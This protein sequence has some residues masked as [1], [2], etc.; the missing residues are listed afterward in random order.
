[1]SSGCAGHGAHTGWR[2]GTSVVASSIEMLMSGRTVVGRK[3]DTF[4]RVAASSGTSWRERVARIV[5]GV[6]VVPFFGGLSL[7]IPVAR[8]RIGDLR[9][10][11]DP[12][13]V[14]L[15]A[16]TL[17]FGL[18]A[19]YGLDQLLTGVWPSRGRWFTRAEEVLGESLGRVR[20]R[21]SLTIGH[22]SGAP[23]RVHWS[24]LVGL[25]LVGGLRPGAWVGFLVVILAH[26]LGHAVLV[27]RFGQRVVALSLHALGGECHW[28]GSPTPRQRTLIAWG[29]VAGQAVLLGLAWGVLQLVPQIFGGWFGNPLGRTLVHSNVVIAAFNLLPIPPLDGVEAWRFLFQRARSSLLRPTQDPVNKVVKSALE[30]ASRNQE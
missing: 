17:F 1:M 7:L 13:E 4:R 6:V 18:I 30:R 3:S 25:I 14:I 27:R 20:G 21:G 10:K 2:E 11:D 24:V 5:F 12:P 16:I 26:E 9:S 29:G 8:A 22:V 23:V 28:V 15:V 19:A